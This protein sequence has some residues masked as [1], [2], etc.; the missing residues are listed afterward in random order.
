[1][2]AGVRLEAEALKF[3]GVT[4]PVFG[5]LDADAQKDVAAKECLYRF[6]RDD[7]RVF[8]S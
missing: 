6:A 2:V 8:E 5:H 3:L 7:A 1:M 4:L